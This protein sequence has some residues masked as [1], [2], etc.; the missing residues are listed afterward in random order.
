MGIG[1]KQK[2]KEVIID[3]MKVDYDNVLEKNFDLAKKFIRITGSGTI[4]I[5][6]KENL[7]T[8][9]KILIYLVGKK[10]AK[11]AQ[12]ADYEGAGNKELKDELGIPEGTLLPGIKHLRDKRMI[13]TIKKDG[14]SFHN[15]LPNLI[16]KVLKKLG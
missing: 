8:N 13:K 12:L 14:L 6:N 7:S 9:D 10:Y 5:I 16:E 11:E 3:G 2:F 1:E 4:D 15:I